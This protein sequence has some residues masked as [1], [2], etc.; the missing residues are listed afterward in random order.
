MEDERPRS[1]LRPHALLDKALRKRDQLP[2]FREQGGEIVARA[3]LNTLATRTW[4]R[5]PS[6]AGLWAARAGE[7]TRTSVKG[8][9]RKAVR[10]PATEKIVKLPRYQG[11][12]GRHLPGA[13]SERCTTPANGRPL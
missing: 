11:A 2:F 9:A 5:N 12:T 6:L 8:L 13:T 7:S 10:L 4:S 1:C 3:G